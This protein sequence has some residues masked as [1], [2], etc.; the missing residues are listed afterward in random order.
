MATKRGA[1]A[2]GA[3]DGRKSDKKWK[4]WVWIPITLIPKKVTTAKPRVT[5]I[6]LVTVKLYGIIPNKLQNNIKENTEK[7]T[8]KYK[9]PPFFTFSVKTL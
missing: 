5:T 8:G 2:I 7:I 6:W 1:N 9:F 3:P 4:P